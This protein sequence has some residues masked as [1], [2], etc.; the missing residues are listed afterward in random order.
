ME[1][2]AVG[3]RTVWQSPLFEGPHLDSSQIGTLRFGRGYKGQRLRFA[4]TAKVSA[5]WMLEHEWLPACL[6]GHQGFRQTPDPD[7]HR[8]GWLVM[9]NSRH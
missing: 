8:L 1:S 2:R 9:A 5:Y 4:G 3:Q 7:E 6:R